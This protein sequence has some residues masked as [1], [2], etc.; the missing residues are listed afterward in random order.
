MRSFLLL[1]GVH[2]AEEL[3]EEFEYRDAKSQNVFTYCNHSRF[4][5]RGR[6]AIGKWL[7]VTL[8]L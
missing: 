6:I 5:A 2:R 4:L 7:E 1:N 3:Q 8:L